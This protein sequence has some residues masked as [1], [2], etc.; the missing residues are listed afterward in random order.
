[1]LSNIEF[2]RSAESN[3][4]GELLS[5]MNIPTYYPEGN[6]F[7]DTSN[8]D[9]PSSASR[10]TLPMYSQILFL[11]FFPTVALT[12]R[13]NLKMRAKFLLFGVLCFLAFIVTEFLTI[14]TIITLGLNRLDV[15]FAQSSLFL[16]TLTA[17]LIIELSFFLT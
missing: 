1:M 14:A 12:A 11:V 16:T 6:I 7:V 2:I 15:S 3:I 5:F 10:L 9:N 13:I 17:A 8:G 4:L